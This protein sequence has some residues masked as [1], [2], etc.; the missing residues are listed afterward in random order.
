MLLASFFAA[1]LACAP[2]AKDHRFDREIQQAVDATHAVY[3]VPLALVRAIIR[4]ESAFHPRA[5]SRAGARGLMQVMP[6]NAR[7][8]GASPDDLWDP[9]KN[10][11]AGVR[12]LAVL[13]AHYQGDLISALV[14]YNARPRRLLAPLPANGETPRYV[15]NVLAFYE[16]Y[17]REAR[18]TLLSPVPANAG[19]ALLPLEPDPS[20]HP[21]HPSAPDAAAGLP[22]APRS[23]PCPR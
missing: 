15:W 3:P 11:S 4:Q 16:Q 10:I 20:T 1:L 5:L 23:T 13:L 22:A 6:A 2:L 21:A 12:L 7:R 19:E 18:G 9:A 17:Q 8:L 14:A